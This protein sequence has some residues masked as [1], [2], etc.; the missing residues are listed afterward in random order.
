MDSERKPNII[1]QHLEAFVSLLFPNLCL[2]CGGVIT[3]QEQVLCIICEN[4]L[5]KTNFHNEKENVVFKRLYGRIPIENATPLFYFDKGNTVQHLM[6][7]LKYRGKKEIGTYLG[8]M[9]GADLLCVE[10]YKSINV[11]IPVPLHERKL[12]IRG[13]NQS[14][15]FAFGIAEAMKINV[16]TNVIKRIEFTDTQTGKNRFERWENVKNA[17][18]VQQ[19]D[20]IKGLHVLLVDDVVTT[21]ATLEACA[22]HLLNIEDVKVSI[23]TIAFAH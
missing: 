8:K 2:G 16:L 11:V 10:E 20:A 13:Y 17:F 6:H 14:D 9:L 22:Q 4:S 19:P 12:R 15:Y 3:A 23:A 21:G 5:P 18:V 7:Q 1:L